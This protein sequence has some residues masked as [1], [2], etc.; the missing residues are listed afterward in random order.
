MG[1]QESI[2]SGSDEPQAHQEFPGYIPIRRRECHPVYVQEFPTWGNLCH[3]F[4]VFLS[5]PVTLD[6]LVWPFGLCFCLYIHC[7]H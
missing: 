4:I 1:N 7:S 2:E 3:P 5:H 6:V